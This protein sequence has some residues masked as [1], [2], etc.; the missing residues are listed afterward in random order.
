MIDRILSD[1][2]D[3]EVQ[4]D[5]VALLLSGGVDSISLGITAQKLGS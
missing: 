1:I 5:E 2:I 4:S 3:R